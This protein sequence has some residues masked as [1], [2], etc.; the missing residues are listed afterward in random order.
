MERRKF[1]RLSTLAGAGII[2]PVRYGFPPR[3]ATGAPG[4]PGEPDPKLLT[5]IA[6]ETARSKGAQYADIRICRYR[7][8]FISTREERVDNISDSENSGFGVR[9]L[10]DGTWG[11]AGSNS[12][13]RQEI[14]RVAAEAVAVAKANKR[15]QRE[16][17]VLAPVPAYNDS[18]KSP[19]KK[20]PWDVPVKEK[21]EFL[22]SLN[23]EALGV[24]GASFCSS[25]IFTITEHKVFAS[26]EGSFIEQEITRL[27]PFA[28][29]TAVDKATGRFETRDTD[30]AP[31]SAGYEYI[32]SYPW[33]E[34]IRHAAEDAVAKHSAKSVVPGKRDLILLPTNLWLTIHESVG[35]PT[36]LDR[37]LGYEANYAGTSFLTPDKWKKLKFG[38]DIVNL[39]A[40]KTYP[41]A[42]A[43]CGY[44]DDGVRTKEWDIIRNGVFV[45]YQTIRDQ[46]HVL[47]QTASDGCSYADNWASVPFQRMPNIS[48]QPGTKPLSLNDLI[49]DTE[50]ALLFKGKASYSIDQQRYN[51]QFSGQTAWEVRNGKMTGMVRDA[52]YQANTVEFWNSCDAICSREEFW[53]G[54]S[55][56]DGKGQPSQ[57]NGVSHGCSPSRFRK[58]NVINTSSRT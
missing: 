39:V 49:A 47:G 36:E 16:P 13:S 51:F 55:M 9:V 41:R 35:H 52:A 30:A 22:L 29:V 43:T 1:L 28:T 57:S 7:N 25:G 45:G 26:T 34:E 48:L 10:V 24:K 27:N 19:M 3:G 31:A 38:S 37:A 54:G 40:D 5:Q 12:V 8:Q 32:E 58:V 56:N 42:L 33:Q 14:V 15:I 44:D 46:A 4:P 53:V 50:D 20:D 11:F 18:W 2:L 6:L 17:V 21:C 23:K